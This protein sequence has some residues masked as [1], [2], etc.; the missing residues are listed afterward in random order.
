M[1]FPASRGGGKKVAIGVLLSYTWI[2]G[3][4]GM[5]TVEENYPSRTDTTTYPNRGGAGF[6]SFSGEIIIKI[7]I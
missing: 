2:G 1:L 5:L 6:Q 3:S 4:R 7:F